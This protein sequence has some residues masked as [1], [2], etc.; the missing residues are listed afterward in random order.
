MLPL[1]V[2]AMIAISPR[3]FQWTVLNSQVQ[4][5]QLKGLL[6]NGEMSWNHGFYNVKCPQTCF[7]VYFQDLNSYFH[8]DSNSH[9]ISRSDSNVGLR[10]T[11][12]SRKDKSES[13]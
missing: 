3:K 7:S 1:K 2:Q 12:Q 10:F 4:L 9:S 5:T 8:T 11:F 6:I 13:L